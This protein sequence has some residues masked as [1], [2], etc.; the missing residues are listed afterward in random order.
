MFDEPGLGVLILLALA[1]LTLVSAVESNEPPD[2]NTDDYSAQF[3]QEELGLTLLPS[4]ILARSEDNVFQSIF[5]KVPTPIIPQQPCIPD[6]TPVVSEIEQ[7]LSLSGNCWV[8][9]KWVSTLALLEV[10]NFDSVAT[11][12]ATCLTRTTCEF[13]TYDAVERVCK[14]QT[15]HMSW[16]NDTVRTSTSRTASMNCLLEK[17]GKTKHGLC[18]NDNSLFTNVLGTMSQKHEELTEKLIQKFEDVKMGYNVDPRAFNATRNKRSWESFDFL[19]DIPVIGHLYDIFKSPVENRKLK[20]HVQNLEQRFLEMAALTEEN[21]R[22]SRRFQNSVLEIL[23]GMSTEIRDRI[24]GLK[25]D[26]VSLS[27][28]M[29][30]EQELKTHY[31]KVE[32][33][34]FSA[35]HKKLKA[36]ISQTLT[37][38]DLKLV[39]RNNPGYE[40]TLFLNFPELLYRVGDLYLLQ[41]SKNSNSMLFHFLLTAPKIKQGSLYQTYTPVTIP[42]TGDRERHCFEVELPNTIIVKNNLFLSADITDCTEKDDVL[43][44]QQD[45]SDRFSP[46][47]KELHCLNNKTEHCKMKEVDCTTKMVFTKAGALVFSFKD[48]L[49]LERTDATKLTLVS[50]EGKYSYF[51]GWSKYQMIQSDQKIIYSIDNKLTVRNLSWTEPKQALDFS[52]YLRKKS[53]ESVKNNVTQLRGLLDNTTELVAED[54]KT[55]YL[56]TDFSRRD[57]NEVSGLVS[58]VSTILTVLGLILIC[59]SKSIRRHSRMLKLL[60]ATTKQERQDARLQK[61]GFELQQVKLHKGTWQDETPEV[62]ETSLRRPGLQLRGEDATSIIS[63]LCG[64]TSRTTTSC[65]STTS[66]D[67]K[68]ESPFN[69]LVL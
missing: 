68:S 13:I 63:K 27:M 29:I 64:R 38:E 12:F 45:F 31:A 44:C 26:L 57:F 47:V 1:S 4:K 23:E 55:G 46:S 40:D 14:L 41:V 11:C 28:L 32:Q 48:I 67:P 18:R 65:L 61:S 22:T 7:W 50:M 9:Q 3:I 10:Y 37:L 20:S 62:A 56:G 66:T 2:E 33:L 52:S 43:F 17:N 60:V 16:R 49:G 42:V 34:F 21:F 39:V 35:I 54:Y 8:Y 30:H 15:S 5:L 36:S 24:E 6:C 19:S 53:L 58:I 59:S 51:L 25:C 69:R